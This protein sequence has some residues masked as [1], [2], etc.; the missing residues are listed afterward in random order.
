MGRLAATLLKLDH[1]NS[2]ISSAP[3]PVELGAGELG[4]TALVGPARAVGAMGFDKEEHSDKAGNG[5]KVDD[6]GG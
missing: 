3:S 2:S 1:S 4:R 5:V 6:R